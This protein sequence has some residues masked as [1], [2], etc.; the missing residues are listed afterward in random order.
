MNRLSEVQ[1]NTSQSPLG[2]TTFSAFTDD[3]FHATQAGQRACLLHVVLGKKSDAMENTLEEFIELAKAAG[4]EICG[5]YRICRVRPMAKYFIGSGK[6]NE[7]K[8]YLEQNNIQLLIINH[9]LSPGQER[10]LEQLCH[11]RV[12]GRSGLIL[13]I[14]SQR[15]RSYEGKLQVEFAQLT[16]LSTRLVRGWSHLE[17]Q[18]GGIGLRGP[19][20]KQLETDR[21]LLGKRMTGIGKRLARIKS[22]R[23][24]G[25]QMRRKHNLPTIALVGYT[26]AG[27]TTLFN[28]LTQ[29]NAYSAD[30]LF[31]TLD[32]MMRKIEFNHARGG[33]TT[34]VI[35]DTVGFISDLPHTLI[36]AF[37]ATL[38]EVREANL[39]LHVV[40]ASDTN[41]TEYQCEVERVLRAIDA[42]E[43][44]HIVVFN[45]SDLTD[46]SPVVVR[47]EKH[48]PVSVTL[49][50]YTGEGIAKLKQAI[51]DLLIPPMRC[52]EVLI[53]A[54]AGG[55]RAF[56]YANGEVVREEYLCDKGWQLQLRL[57]DRVVGG[58][59]KYAN[60]LG[61][62]L[63]LLAL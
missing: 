57:A 55:L 7:I 58:L 44:P 14:F 39:L 43:I 31:A 5:L 63:E 22:C 41:H 6:A 59:L 13:D 38:L 52:Y 17:R 15:A 30:S 49:S 18:K 4:V 23:L 34:A 10:N 56:I 46:R 1:H 12:L 27:K 62:R 32:P 54:N 47:D 33:N 42:Y 24:L 20:E 19:G 48:R 28:R 29:S 8:S 35:S 40:D 21:R 25:R 53:P 37:N 50:A 51:A 9:D 16:Y 11:A 3:T 60:N 36:E 26:N 45:K 2:G 61:H